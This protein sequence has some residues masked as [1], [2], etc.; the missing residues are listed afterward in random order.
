MRDMDQGLRDPLRLTK[1]RGR[2]QPRSAP[3]AEI[4]R[5]YLPPSV[6][7]PLGLSGAGCVA[8]FVFWTVSAPGCPE[9]SVWLVSGALVSPVFMS[10]PVLP[11]MLDFISPD[12]AAGLDAS[13]FFDA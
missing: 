3:I 8:S 5:A 9:A 13:V 7:L 2:A 1:R 11:P 6:S 12:L 10:I 4:T